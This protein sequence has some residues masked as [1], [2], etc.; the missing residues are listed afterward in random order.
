M[1]NDKTEQDSVEENS[2]EKNSLEKSNLEQDKA[3]Q[4]HSSIDMQVAHSWTY[5]AINRADVNSDE[6]EYISKTELKN[7]AKELHRFG[8]Q[9][10]LLSREKVNLLP[11]DETTKYAVNDFHKQVG[12]IA[13][14]RHLAYIAKCLR[15]DDKVS[16]SMKVLE[17]DSFAQ[18]RAVAAH[19]KN[20]AKTEKL[21][22]EADLLNALLENTDQQIQLLIEQYP[23]L[24]RQKLRQLSRNFQKAKTEAKK[25]QAKNKILDFFVEN[26]I[27]I[28]LFNC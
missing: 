18:L 1:S 13:K 24:D 21:E 15:S 14:K 27:D 20:K 28:T 26:K 19:Q 23:R 3:E 6:D 11:L 2:F 12:N 16:T 4:E 17:Q 25:L 9:L 5:S 10:V 8:K 7:D 22:S